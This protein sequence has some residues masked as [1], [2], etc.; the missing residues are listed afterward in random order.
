MLP[1]GAGAQSQSFIYPDFSTNSLA[2][3]PLQINGNAAAP[4]VGAEG[5]PVLRLTPAQSDQAGSAFGLYAIQLGNDASFSTAFAFQMTG[6]GGISD[7]TTNPPGADGIVFV[8]TTLGNTVG[9]LGEGVG[10][11]GLQSSVGIKFDTWQDGAASFPQD[12]DPNGNF[13]AVYTNGNTETSGYVPYSPSNPSTDAQ[14]YS[15]STSMKNG[16]IWYAWIDYNGQTG[17]LDVRLSD[18]VGARPAQP[19][20]SQSVV[21]DAPSILG[22]SPAVYAGFTSA[23]GGAWDNHD[24]LMW[25]FYG[26]FQ[27]ISLPALTAVPDQSVNAGSVLLVTNTATEP[28]VPPRQITFSLGGGAPAQAGVSADGVF[29]WAPTCDQGS[30]TNLITV[31]AVDNGRPALSNSVSFTVTV[32]SC[33][34][35]TVGSGAVVLGQD[36][37]IPVTLFSTVGLTN[38][39]FSLATLA[40]RFSN[41]GV[42]ST[43][44]AI[45]TGVAQG[46]NASQPQFTFAV[47]NGQV[48]QG[49]SMLG[50]I[51]V[52]A[53]PAGVSAFA[54]LTVTDIAAATVNHNPVGTAL[55]QSG[56]M[57]LIGAQPMLAASLATNSTPVV[58]IFGNVG[59]N[60]VVQQTASLSP[61]IRWTTFTSLTMTDIIQTIDL[62]GDTNPMDFFRAVQP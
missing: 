21:L 13:V 14:Y 17:E 53:L 61:P 12:S 28:F 7:G 3:N 55:G 16:D 49:T 57:L 56:R 5:T 25:K 20:L 29:R 45:A 4:V 10:Y 47:Q 22:S 58:T 62:G 9:G 48:L 50:T 37:F 27:P 36:A 46:T 33:V 24:I 30:T 41:W 31:W 34:E 32:G 38:L 6:G 52:D 54:P 2:G 23:T 42:S 39:D 11:E 18:S 43:N 59:S 60:Y 26:T 8:L 35:V 15:P 51:S 40:G 44:P 1:I 19:Q